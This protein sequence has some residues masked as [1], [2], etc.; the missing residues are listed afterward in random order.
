MAGTVTSQVRQNDVDFIAESGTIPLR[1]SAASITSDL[2]KVSYS[3]SHSDLAI[4]TLQFLHTNLASP[5]TRDTKAR[6]ILEKDS[7]SESVFMDFRR[8]VAVAEGSHNDFVFKSPVVDYTLDQEKNQSLVSSLPSHFINRIISAAAEDPYIL[9]LAVASH[10]NENTS[11]GFS[12]SQANSIHANRLSQRSFLISHLRQPNVLMPEQPMTLLDLNVASEARKLDDPD[13]VIPDCCSPSSLSG[14][15]I[16]MPD[17]KV[18]ESGW[19]IYL[20]QST[21]VSEHRSSV[22]LSRSDSIIASNV[23]RSPRKRSARHQ[24]HCAG[25]NAAVNFEDSSMVSDASSG[26]EQP[27]FYEDAED[28][29]EDIAF[30]KKEFCA[31]ASRGCRMDDL[32]DDACTSKL[33]CENISC[34]P[35]GIGW[36]MSKRRKRELVAEAFAHNTLNRNETPQVEDETDL[37]SSEGSGDNWNT[38]HQSTAFRNDERDLVDDRLEMLQQLIPNS[39]KLDREEMLAVAID[40]VKSLELKIKMFETATMEMAD[41]GDM[42]VIENFPQAPALLV[43]G[44]KSAVEGTALQEKGLCLMPVSLLGNAL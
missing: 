17:T 22:E 26:P 12:N 8:S 16:C 36:R 1:V 20:D 27:V 31:E 35:P 4:P 25:K 13:R 40:Y 15:Q 28:L 21:D 9:N 37:N 33:S 42:G 2:P 44:L 7:L 43:A 6:Q 3:I 29:S 5:T 14:R 19:T 18:S 41:H 32:K 38:E 11:G 24:Q 30:G 39:E 10:G 23:T 34:G